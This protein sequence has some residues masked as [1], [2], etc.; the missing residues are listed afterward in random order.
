MSSN[1]GTVERIN[2]RD[3]QFLGHPIGL[4]VLFTTEMWERFCYYGMRAFLVMYLYYS[5]SSSNPG[6]GWSEKQSYEL[7]G[8]FTGLVYLFPV[9]G[10]YIADRF[11][12]QHR[13]VLYGGVMIAAGEF[14]LFGTEYF[15]QYATSSVTLQSCPA[16]WFMFM[17]GLGL[18]IV[19]NGFFKP[20][21]SVM[22]G[23]LYGKRDSRRDVAFTI[24]YMGINVG[25]LLA[26][27]VAGT[28]AEKIAWHW[29]FLTAAIGMLFG[30]TTY[31]LLRPRYLGH[32]GMLDSK[33][34]GAEEE[35][36]EDNSTQ[37]NESSQAVQQVDSSESSV[38]QLPPLTRK[39]IDRTIVILVLSAFCVAFWSVFEQAGSSLNT[40]AKKDTNRQVPTAF[41]Q[42]KN[43]P[44]LANEDETDALIAIDNMR[45]AMTNASS[46]IEDM[47]GMDEKAKQLL[48]SKGSNDP[49][50]LD[51]AS[52]YDSASREVQDGLATAKRAALKANEA[53]KK[54]GLKPLDLTI[55]T[56]DQLLEQGKKESAEI[57]QEAAKRFNE[58]SGKSFGID[59]GKGPLDSKT[60]SEKLTPEQQTLFDGICRD[61]ERERS[62]AFE[63]ART[64]NAVLEDSLFT[65][66]ATWYQ[67]V[68][69]LGIVVFAPLFAA[70]W[71]F[72][73]YRRME[74][75]TPV[76]FGVGLVVLGI[77]NMFMVSGG[78]QAEKTGGNAAAYWLFITYIFCTW[79]E[80]C[81]SPVGLSMVS[82]LAPKR[83]VSA[84]MGVWFLSS[85]IAC[86]LSGKLVAV[87]G[88]AGAD[89]S[90]R[91]YFWFGRDGGW[92]DYFLLMSLVPLAAGV[93]VFLLAPTLRR[94]MHEE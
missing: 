83:Y 3:R 45:Q 29:G 37:T 42:T 87:L 40:F 25:A 86:Y 84:L 57:L 9:L 6:F 78:I 49:A 34:V 19:G 59:F 79:G 48:F 81:L 65:F 7:Y 52:R 91:I 75:S 43:H 50:V 22:V 39:E 21:I 2:P 64:K 73:A 70:L 16:A 89:G 94:M 82:R 88:S 90:G 56:M 58:G 44:F 54:A 93:L 67:S 77:A 33:E 23:E 74:P 14:M 28:V 8:W 20:C 38:K 51:A 46:A 62:K 71:G 15:R 41:A 61:V 17:I 60:V 36:Q 69:P 76:K 5:V 85:S 66:P 80:L 68:N 12:G 24:F 31:S 53:R 27:L 18:I 11:I 92:A 10:G 63:E 35:T 32:I 55:P 30:L 47:K 4:W 13:S 1:V 26:P 72:L